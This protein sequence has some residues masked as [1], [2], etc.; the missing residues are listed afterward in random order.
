MKVVVCQPVNVVHDVQTLYKDHRLR[1]NTN[2]EHALSN[3]R[4]QAERL[5]A[6]QGELVHQGSGAEDLASPWPDLLRVSVL[7]SRTGRT[8]AASR[9]T[10]ATSCLPRS[11]VQVLEEMLRGLVPQDSTGLNRLRDVPSDIVRRSSSHSYASAEPS[12][13]HRCCFR[14][15]MNI[16]QQ[17]TNVHRSSTQAFS[18]V[19][20]KLQR[21]APVN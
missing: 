18:N 1:F 12:V 6:R 8:A 14:H 19:A 20:A 2:T 16:W 10:S 3:G 21:Q 17:C 4:L 9:S 11:M 5:A 13:S 7:S 15:S